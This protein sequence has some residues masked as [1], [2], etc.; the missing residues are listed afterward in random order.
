MPDTLY[1]RLG[2]AKG[3]AAIAHDIVTLHLQNPRIKNR[4]EVVKDKAALETHVRTF[5]GSG[6]GGPEVYAGR[7][8]ATAHRGMNIDEA[9]LVAAIDDVLKALEKNGVVEADR[10]EILAVLYGLKG[11]VMFK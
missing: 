10:K 6:T 8:M 3:V 7:D 1:D 11:E 2:G 4:F 9:E 5:L